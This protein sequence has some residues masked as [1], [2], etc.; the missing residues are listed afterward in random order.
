MPLLVRQLTSSTL[1]IR[2]DSG[3]RQHRLSA[4]AAP[5]REL[6]RGVAPQET[7]LL[8]ISG[9]GERG[10]YLT[11]GLLAL[12]LGVHAPALTLIGFF[13]LLATTAV[14]AGLGTPPWYDLIAKV[15]PARRRGIWAGFSRGLG[16]LLGIGG[17]TLAGL[18]L[19]TYPYPLGFSLCFFVAFISL[20]ISWVSLALNREPDSTITKP[21]V[22]LSVYLRQLPTIL[23][24]D[25]NYL[26]YLIARSVAVLGGM[27][28]GFHG[29]RRQ[30]LRR[31]GADGRAAHRGAG[32]QPGAHEYTAGRAGRS[33]GTRVI[34]AFSALAMALAAASVLLAP[35]AAWLVLSFALLGASTAASLVS[36]LNII[37]EFC[38]P[39]DRPTYIGLT[40]TLLAP[41]T[42]DRAAH[43]RRAGASVRLSKRVCR[44]GGAG[45]R[46]ERAS[47]IVWVHEPRFAGRAEPTTAA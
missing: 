34:L 11:I 5:D 1:A 22:K 3:D 45:S 7:L 41:A 13:L 14:A 23:R 31:G 40:N 2:P 46:R 47:L 18:L 35:S 24:R 16:S 28:A 15:I 4:A 19:A 27:G 29:L 8:I 32:R 25:A 10:P 36:G 12:T 26:H 43:W 44:S 39:E 20:A 42:A 9:I 21:R 30:P 6:R 33:G 17:A 37:L 38:A